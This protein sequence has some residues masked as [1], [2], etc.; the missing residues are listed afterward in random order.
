MVNRTELVTP[1]TLR[2]V[3]KRVQANGVQ[4][5]DGHQYVGYPLAHNP[6]HF[7]NDSETVYL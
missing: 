6:D 4:A 5:P 1:A 7:A 3:W 2:G